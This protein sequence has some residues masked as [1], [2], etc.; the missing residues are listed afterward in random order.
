MIIKI[1]IAAA[2]ALILALG[3]H[4]VSAVNS[5]K[6][7]EIN[8]IQN[9]ELK[10]MTKGKAK[11]SLV[12]KSFNKNPRTLEFNRLDIDIFSNKNRIGNAK[13]NTEI[14]IPAE[15]QGLIPL[16]LEI[17][18]N[19]L[20]NIFKLSEDSLKLSL[21]GS[22]NSRMLFGI[23]MKKS[24]NQEISLPVKETIRSLMNKGD[25]AGKI[26]RLGKVGISKLGLMNSEISLGFFVSNPY[27][28][29][30]Q[31]NDYD[32]R[33]FLNGTL[34]GTGSLREPMEIRALEKNKEGS[35]LFHGNN[36]KTIG[37]SLKAMLTGKLKYRTE[38][39]LKL[40]V[41]GMDFSLPAN[42]EGDMLD[43]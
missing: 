5:M 28:I 41:M 35:F 3:V 24:I 30:I 22:L 27:G 39:T 9:L 43:L 14:E 19:G 17:D 11:L 12:L 15:S 21:K 29:P 16:D 18:T 33:I 10:E 40:E 32:S 1:I 2:G 36:I 26:F 25:L 31:L 34:A 20:S 7:P 37:S 23:N 4:K 8:G 6:A 38:G 13:S 42:F